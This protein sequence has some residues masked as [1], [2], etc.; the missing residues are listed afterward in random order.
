[1]NLKNQK[2]ISMQDIRTN[3]ASIA[4]RAEEG[5]EFVVLKHSKP[6]FRILP[7][8]SDSN[9]DQKEGTRVSAFFDD[10]EERQEKNPSNVTL[11]DVVEMVHDLRKEMQANP[12]K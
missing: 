11:E 12:G 7:C 5:E 3:L 10:L 4:R 6:A 2:M 1:M 9:T 8:V